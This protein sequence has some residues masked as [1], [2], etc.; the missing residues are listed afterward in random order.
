[1]E[2]KLTAVSTDSIKDHGLV[3]SVDLEVCLLAVNVDYCALDRAQSM[4]PLNN[5]SLRDDS[6]EGKLG[7][8]FATGFLRAIRESPRTP[9]WHQHTVPAGNSKPLPSRLLDEKLFVDRNSGIGARG[10]RSG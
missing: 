6:A 8:E 1:M 2:Q 9:A 7:Q 4:S 10:L 3:A 5:F